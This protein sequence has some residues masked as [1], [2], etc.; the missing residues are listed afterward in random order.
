MQI[1]CLPRLHAE[2]KLEEFPYWKDLHGFWRTLP[3]FNP[4]TVSSE[5]G[6]DL[7]AE[8]TEFL[9]Q[10]TAS[11]A[12]QEDQADDDDEPGFDDE[13]SVVS[14]VIHVVNRC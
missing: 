13:S 6:Q 8:A 7:E 12:T 11:T 1:L 9:Q 2:K 3:N 10:P 14:P 5:P 4:H